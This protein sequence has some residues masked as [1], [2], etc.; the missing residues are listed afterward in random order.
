MITYIYSYVYAKSEIYGI[1]F[2]SKSRNLSSYTFIGIAINITAE[3]YF[4]NI[5]DR[6][7]EK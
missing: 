4:M 7:R 3:I 2:V 1:S 6:R 5:A